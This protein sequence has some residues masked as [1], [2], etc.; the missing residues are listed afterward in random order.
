MK[1][2]MNSA[3]ISALVIGALAHVKLATQQAAEKTVER[4]KRPPAGEG[5]PED[6]SW[7]S[8]FGSVAC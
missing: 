7:L 8:E 3:A 1:I 2:T 4:L 5:L 6:D